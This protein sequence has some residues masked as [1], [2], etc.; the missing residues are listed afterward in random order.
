MREC[1]LE[2]LKM[3]K[4]RELNDGGGEQRT[5]Y[6]WFRLRRVALESQMLLIF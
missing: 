2:S 6:E 1:L 5:L 4:A 3:L